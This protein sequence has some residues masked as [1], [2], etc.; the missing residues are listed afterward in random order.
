MGAAGRREAAWPQ[1]GLRHERIPPVQRAPTLTR[2][3]DQP[4]SQ[5]VR[6][7][8]SRPQA[9]F[10]M[11]RGRRNGV[12]SLHSRVD[13]PGRVVEDAT[14]LS[15]PYPSQI[16]QNVLS[17]DTGG[18]LHAG[19][20]IRCRLSLPFRR[21]VAFCLRR[22]RKATGPLSTGEELID[23]LRVPA[24]ASGGNTDWPGQG[25]RADH[26]VECRLAQTGYPFNLGSP[27]D[28]RRCHLY[29]PG[30]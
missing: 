22:R 17:P 30:D 29:P 16:D 1:C 5:G 14:E 12:K 27:H 11:R 18:P 25:P 26:P 15:R 4:R 3:G 24:Y 2:R 6:P 23:L 19:P 9:R 20:S 10:W 13:V 28:S 8:P 21:F 7:R